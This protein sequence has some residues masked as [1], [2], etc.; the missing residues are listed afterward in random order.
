MVVETQAV[1]LI[2]PALLF[3]TIIGLLELFFIHADESFR[4]SHW[5][6]HGLHSVGWAIIAVFAVMN[7]DYVY[8]VI[9][10][11]TTIPIISNALYLQ[12]AIGFFTMIKTYTTSAVIAGAAGRGMH[13][14]IWHCLI[15]GL[16]V[17]AS[18]Y[19]YQAVG[20]LLPDVLK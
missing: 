18:P 7:I 20:P 13:E 1:L 17:M 16:L 14:K 3:G 6:G 15:V 8:S 19:I 9:P 11:L 2:K 4:G 5:F 12:I 10:S